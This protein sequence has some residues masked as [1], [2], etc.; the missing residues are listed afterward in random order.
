MS[1]MNTCKNCHR[2]TT[3]F[4]CLDCGKI[5]EY[6]FISEDS[7]YRS[8]LD[9][10]VKDLLDRD[11]ETKK[12]IRELMDKDKLAEAIYNN[13]Y[14][15][16]L[17]L[18]KLCGDPKI[19]DTFGTLF[20]IMAG[21]IKKSRRNECQIAIVG[22][23]KAG[24]SM[25]VNSIL[26]KEI[27]STYPTPET[28]AL[29]KFR[30]SDKGDYVKI[31][32]YTKKEWEE[33]WS[34]VMEAEESYLYRD[35][36]E[37]FLSLYNELK[38]EEIKEQKIDKEPEVYSELTLD[39]LKNIVERFSSAK[40]PEHFFVK[41]V[42]VGLSE[43]NIDI[44]KNVVF[45]DTPGLNDAVKFRSS[46]TRRYIASANVVLL[47]VNAASAE[48]RAQEL[49]DIGRI[50][51]DM[52]YAKDRLYIFGTQFDR[53]RDKGLKFKEYWEKYTKPE[54]VKWLSKDSY[55]GSVE[56]AEERIIPISSWYYLLIQRAKNDPS[57]WA[58]NREFDE[59]AEMVHRCLGALRGVDPEIRF[60]ESIEEIEAMTNV[61]SVRKTLSDGPIKNAE[62]I[63]ADDVI[64]IYKGI[65]KDANE[66]SVRRKDYNHTLASQSDDTDTER[67]IKELEET[68]RIQK[69]SRQRHEESL[70]E[71]LNLGEQWVK[72]FINKVKNN[73]IYG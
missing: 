26:G 71:A 9:G 59:L 60:Y 19:A 33:L 24:K 30:Y 36:K 68:L 39:Q 25:F 54:F 2:E 34:S 52:R 67:V 65:F 15:R 8:N 43:F 63:M 47:C 10:F 66:L 32:Y 21:A 42:E 70:R 57:L 4:F 13:E 14:K 12:K 35:D 18:Q 58:E 72:D 69:E 22:T 51:S 73:N 40:Y 27:A 56:K 3:E 11:N 1:N 7:E 6:P 49:N 20:D 53:G 29:T 31:T 48:M 41:E 37:D 28:A 62:K 64:N 44:P 61:C 50:F 46:I 17:R 45:I 16:M 55:F 5:I 38:A 23:I